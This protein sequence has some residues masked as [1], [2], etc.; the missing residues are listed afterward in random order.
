[1]KITDIES[2]L[3]ADLL[4]I[5]LEYNEYSGQF[6]WRIPPKN[7]S[8]KIGDVAGYLR[9]NGYW[10]IKIGGRSYSA[11]RLAWMYVHGVWP[12]RLID[13]I[14]GVKSDNR[15]DNLRPASMSQNK[16]NGALYASSSS[17]FKGV[18]KCKN[19]WKAQI[20]HNQVVVYLGLFNTREEAHETYLKAASERQG[21]FARA[22]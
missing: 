14:N 5:V 21:A 15:I 18:T 3:T 17:G 8:I 7:Q 2:T 20:T 6:I 4:R 11:H 19:K 10:Y 22:A 12:P 1:M 16:A 9:S 13:H